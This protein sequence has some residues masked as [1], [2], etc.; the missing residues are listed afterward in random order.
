MTRAPLAALILAAGAAAAQGQALGDSTVTATISQTFEF[1]DNYRLQEDP[2]PAAY[3][4]TR[5]RLDYLRETSTRQL[6]LFGDV[7]LRLL[8]EDGED[9]DV[10]AADP[11]ILGGRYGQDWAD[12][13]FDAYARYLYRRLDGVLTPQEFSVA[14]DSLANF[15]GNENRISAGFDL[16]LRTNSPSSYLFSLDATTVDYSNIDTDQADSAVP[17]DAI[18]GEALWTLRLTP[19]LSSGV[20]ASYD[21]E[22]AENATD[23]EIRTA[24]IDAGV[25]YDPSENLNVT[26]GL[27]YEQRERLQTFSGERIT[28]ENNWGPAVRGGISYD[29]P[30]EFSIVANA[31]YTTAAPDPRWT[32]DFQGDYLLPRGRLYAL[33]YREYALDIEGDDTLFYGVG[34]GA[35][36]EINSLS[37]WG[38]DVIA[39]NEVD[40]ENPEV[41][42]IDQI[43]A[44]ARYTYDLTQ[45]VSATLGYRLRLQTEDGSA[46][47]NAVFVTFGRSW[48]RRP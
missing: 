25:I 46:Q 11:A 10:T 13:G 35:E 32:G 30:E 44:T 19:I 20:V 21:Y 9:F 45:D 14:P 27:G 3:S 47:S 43:D 5:F 36:R 23:N 8:W 31:R 38:V 33:G 6:A 24:A 4:D 26:F 28:T 34:L 40:T 1:D 29:T 16:A 48:S 18:A 37:R 22:K 41:A 15:D 2:D 39:A 42:A 12:G 17:S 7:G